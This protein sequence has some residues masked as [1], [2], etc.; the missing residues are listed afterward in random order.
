M[1]H[2]EIDL[3]NIHFKGGGEGCKGGRD[4]SKGSEK[5]FERKQGR[6]RIY[7]LLGEGVPDAKRKAD[8]YWASHPLERQ[9]R[10]LLGRAGAVGGG[11]RLGTMLMTVVMSI[12]FLSVAGGAIRQG[13]A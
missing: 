3:K 9:A 10:E 13:D 12:A 11:S 7:L 8:G 1:G 2:C 4:G 6:R 5:G